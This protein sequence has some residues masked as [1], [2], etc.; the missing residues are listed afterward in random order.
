MGVS[1]TSTSGTIPSEFEYDFNQTDRRLAHTYS[2]KSNTGNSKR[3]HRTLVTQSSSF[4][5]YKKEG[6]HDISR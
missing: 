4:C 2:Y 5:I 3:A 6:I 1:T